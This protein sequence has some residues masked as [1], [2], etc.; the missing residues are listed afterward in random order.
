MALAASIYMFF[1]KRYWIRFYHGITLTIIALSVVS[2]A[3]V[4][5]MN[6][7][8]VDQLS[9]LSVFADKGPAVSSLVSLFYAIDSISVGSYQ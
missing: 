3:L 5:G 4:C 7:A 8:L 6:G 9:H 1:Q 2:A